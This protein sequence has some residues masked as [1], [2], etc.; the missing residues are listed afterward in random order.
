[1]S[2][3]AATAGVGLVDHAAGYPPGYIERV[4]DSVHTVA[5][6]GA[7][8]DAGRPSHRVMRALDRYFQKHFGFDDLTI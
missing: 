8:A 7:S 2:D 1:M 3:A 4:L 6:V 5:V